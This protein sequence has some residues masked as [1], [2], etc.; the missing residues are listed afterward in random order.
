[1]FV[2][3]EV[4]DEDYSVLLGL[5][6]RYDPRRASELRHI[7]E[8]AGYKLARPSEVTDTPPP[9]FEPEPGYIENA[10]R[11]NLS[12][13]SSPVYRVYAGARAELKRQGMKKPADD[14]VMSAAIEAA[15][16]LGL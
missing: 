16:A 7:F 6:H 13:M 12:I 9:Q 15:E 10:L 8:R 1:M 4:D 11:K 5:I 3:G 14:D 2:A